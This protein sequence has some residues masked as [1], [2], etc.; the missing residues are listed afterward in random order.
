MLRTLFQIILRECDD[1]RKPILNL[2]STKSQAPRFCDVIV[3]GE[4]VTLEVKQ[5]RDKVE[6]IDWDDLV[7]QV[8]VARELAESK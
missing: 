2:R 4:S 7:Y 3:E 5:D 8:K 1:M 6:T